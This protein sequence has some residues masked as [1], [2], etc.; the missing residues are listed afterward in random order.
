MSVHAETQKFKEPQRPDR[1]RGVRRWAS[2]AALGIAGF[3]VS[4]LVFA[5]ASFFGSP[6]PN[7]P[8]P[9]ARSGMA[10]IPGGEFTMGTDSDLGWAEEKPS[11]RVRVDGFWMDETDV[12]NAQFRRFVEATGYVTTA[13]QAAE[14]GRHPGAATARHTAAPQGKPGPRIVG[15]HADQRARIAE[16][17]LAVVEV[18]ARCQLA[19]PAKA[20]AAIWREAKIIRSC[21]SPGTTP[22]RMRS[23]PASG[24]RRRP[25]GNSPLAAVS[26]T[27]P[28][29]GATIRRRTPA[30][31]RTS[32][33]ASSRTRTRPATGIVNTSPVKAFTPNGYGLYDMSGNVWQWCSDW[34]QIDLYRERVGKGVIVNPHGPEKS[35]DPRQPY[36]PL[37]VQKGG[38]FLC[39]DSYCSR[40]RPS[41]G[42]AARPI[43]ACRT[44]GFAACCLRKHPRTPVS[45]LAG[46]F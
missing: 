11:H 5:G 33:R 37:R 45:R 40:Y 26:T 8:T 1:L 42:T 2:L 43:P 29:S 34:Y 21:T 36:S 18:D 7:R 15:L 28:T 19:A 46:E 3:G 9:A 4:Y 32:G 24:C 25:S 30:F 44:S 22:S 31:T 13:E 14:C 38:S 20:P 41:A 16:R 17:L 12:T 27:S 23:G 39:C 35:F 6:A 10:W